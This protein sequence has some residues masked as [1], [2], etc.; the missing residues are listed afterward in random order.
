MNVGDYLDPSIYSGLPD[1]YTG[2][3]RDTQ[4]NLWWVEKGIV[5]RLEIRA[6][7]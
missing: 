1:K 4:E 2:W 3:Y 7:V 6:K 5:I